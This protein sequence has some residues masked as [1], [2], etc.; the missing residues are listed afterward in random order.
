MFGAFKKNYVFFVEER[1]LHS[2][3]RGDVV[4]LLGCPAVTLA[5][6]CNADSGV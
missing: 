1:K 4:G 2:G 3:T 6:S 5:F